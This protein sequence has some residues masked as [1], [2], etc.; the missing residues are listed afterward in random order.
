MTCFYS[1]KNG[2][3]GIERRTFYQGNAPAHATKIRS[4]RF[5]W[6]KQ[7]QSVRGGSLGRSPVPFAPNE[8]KERGDYYRQA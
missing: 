4:N 3:K 8:K 6:G 5:L 2:Q 1:W 7:Q